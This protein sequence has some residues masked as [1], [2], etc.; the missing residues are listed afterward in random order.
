MGKQP[1]RASFCRLSVELVAD[2]VDVECEVRSGTEFG[3]GEVGNL[4]LGLYS[5]N[6]F[7][8]IYY[9]RGIC[10]EVHVGEVNGSFCKLLAADCECG[11][12]EYLES[13]ALDV[14]DS[15]VC[16][17]LCAFSAGFAESRD[18]YGTRL[19]ALRPVCRDLLTTH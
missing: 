10:G 14:L 3:L 9:C 19:V 8:G 12:V 6:L 16:S 5:V 2:A 4:T 18:V 11:S 15:L 17:F 7:S 1:Y 13:T